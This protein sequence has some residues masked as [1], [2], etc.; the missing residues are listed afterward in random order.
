VRWALGPTVSRVL[1]AIA[2]VGVVPLVFLRHDPPHSQVPPHDY[3]FRISLCFPLRYLYGELVAR[4][5]H[6]G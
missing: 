5:L 6:T 1:D 4:H 2:D 3:S